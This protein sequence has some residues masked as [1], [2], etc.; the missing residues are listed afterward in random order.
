VSECICYRIAFSL[1]DCLSLGE[2]MRLIRLPVFFISWYISLPNI[3]YKVS[4]LSAMNDGCME[5]ISILHKP[6]LSIPTWLEKKRKIFTCILVINGESSRLYISRTFNH[7]TQIFEYLATGL[8]VNKIWKVDVG[9]LVWATLLFLLNLRVL[10]V[11]GIFQQTVCISLP[12]Y[13]S[14]D[15]LFYLPTYLTN[16][17]SK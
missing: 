1:V 17:V 13:V 12:V 4:Y 15:L 8:K 5:Q 16:L 10:K 9:Y 3:V 7:K 6:L 14:S 2:C 11:T